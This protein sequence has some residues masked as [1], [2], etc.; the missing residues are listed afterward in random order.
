MPL[1]PFRAP[2]RPELRMST[3]TKRPW[4]VA[5]KVDTREQLRWFPPAATMATSRTDVQPTTRHP[6]RTDVLPTTR[7]PFAELWTA[8]TPKGSEEEHGELILIDMCMLLG[9]YLLHQTDLWYSPIKWETSDWPITYFTV[10]SVSH[11]SKAFCLS[12]T[13][14]FVKGRLLL[15]TNFFESLK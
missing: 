2:R 3:T 1:L 7:H 4:L 9:I 8:S 5:H 12:I 14:G 11:C 15:C 6:S 13:F 10:H